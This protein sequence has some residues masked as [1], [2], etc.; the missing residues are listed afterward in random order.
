MNFDSVQVYQGLD[1][2]SA[3]VRLSERGGI[4]HHLL[5]VVDATNEL[6]AGE[7]ARMAAATLNELRSRNV[8]PVLAGGTGF[9]LTG[10]PGGSFAGPAARCKAS[11]STFGDTKAPARGT[12]PFPTHSRPLCRATYSC[13]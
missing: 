13:Q 6:S 5:D 11:C 8:L 3:K 7:Y 12:P 10:A 9:Y 1:I 4:A 2:G